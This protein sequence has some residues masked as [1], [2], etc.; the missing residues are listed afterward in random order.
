MMEFHISRDARNRYHFAETLFSFTGNV[1]FANVAASRELAHR[2]NQ[3]RDAQ[4]YPEYAVN[5]GALYQITQSLSSR[6]AGSHFQIYQMEL[7]AKFRMGVM[8]VGANTH[9][10]LIKGQ[11]GFDADDGEIQGIRQPQLD[12]LL[13]PLDHPLE[14]KSG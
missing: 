14:H 7:I 11:S 9:Q 13:P 6:L 4:K 3:V 2:M 8:Q 12:A 1:V 5:A 10:C